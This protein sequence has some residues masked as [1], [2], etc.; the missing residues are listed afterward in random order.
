LRIG[1]NYVKSSS[2]K[3]EDDNDKTDYPD[4]CSGDLAR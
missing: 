3:K 1:D 2:N 4:G